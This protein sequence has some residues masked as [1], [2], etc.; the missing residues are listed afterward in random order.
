MRT[1]PLSYIGKQEFEDEQDFTLQSVGKKVGGG[2]CFYLV[3]F[4]CKSTSLSNP[5]DLRLARA[6]SI[7][8]MLV[9]KGNTF[10]VFVIPEKLE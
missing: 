1:F 7:Y 5:C 6:F 3:F 10:T 4:T 8:F 2:T 9:P